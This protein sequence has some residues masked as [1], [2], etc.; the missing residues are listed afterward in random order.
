MS[1]LG[2]YKAY[3]TFAPDY[4]T[5]KNN[6]D[7]QEAKRIEYLKQNPNK[8]NLEDIQ[9]GK[10]LLRSI[11]IMDHHPFFRIQLF[12]RLIRK[13]ERQFCHLVGIDITDAVYKVS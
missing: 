10:A 13:I 11:D 7:L 4:L 1:I 3:K 2:D 8:I 9:R 5:W 12:P 6:R